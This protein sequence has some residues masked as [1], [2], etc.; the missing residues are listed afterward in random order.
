MTV[1]LVDST[2][3]REKVKIPTNL[4]VSVTPLDPTFD[5]GHR[6]RKSDELLQFHMFL[7]SRNEALTRNL[8][9]KIT[10]TLYPQDPKQSILQL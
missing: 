10:H 8:T 7:G 4:K 1:T 6:S 9:R 2:I 5:P 3:S